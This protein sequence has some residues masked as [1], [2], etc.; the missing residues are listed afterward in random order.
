MRLIDAGMEL[1]DNIDIVLLSGL[2]TVFV[3]T[4]IAEIKRRR[5]RKEFE[6]HIRLY[7]K[8]KK[9]QWEEKYNE[10]NDMH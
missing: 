10:N 5:D 6:E 3:C 8:N 7:I 4:M 2:A 1:I 9:H